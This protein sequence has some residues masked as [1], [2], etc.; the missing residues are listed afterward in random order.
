MGVRALTLNGLSDERSLSSAATGGIPFVL[1]VA[2][3][4]STTTY[5]VWDKSCPR[6]CRIIDV[7]GIMTG[8]GAALDTVK[9]TDGTNDITDTVDLS[10]KGDTDRFSVGELDDDYTDLNAGASLRVVTVSDA[11]VRLYIVGV[12]TD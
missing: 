9:V 7:Y 12:W 10:A 3:K 8:A 6:S 2:T 11:L 1:E 5:R 4:A